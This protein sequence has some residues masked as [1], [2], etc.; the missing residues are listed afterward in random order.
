MA[1][2]GSDH[3]KHSVRP[4]LKPSLTAPLLQAQLPRVVQ[5]LLGDFTWLKPE[6]LG[7]PTLGFGGWLWGLGLIGFGAV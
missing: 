2:S 1:S 4:K 7:L 3:S 5:H 6:P